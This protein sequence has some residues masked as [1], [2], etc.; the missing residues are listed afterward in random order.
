MWGERRG[1]EEDSQECRWGC[2]SENPHLVLSETLAGQTQGPV[3]T[4]RWPPAA[5]KCKAVL[6]EA[7]TAQTLGF[8]P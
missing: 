1:Q 2:F 7:A 5:A 6:L 4:H 8:A 3:H